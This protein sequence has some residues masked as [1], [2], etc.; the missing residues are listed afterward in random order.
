M[1]NIAHPQSSS[2][3]TRATAALIYTPPPSTA[4]HA[5]NASLFAPSSSSQAR[6]V[7]NTSTRNHTRTPGP[8]Y[9]ERY[10]QRYTLPSGIEEQP[11]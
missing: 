4:T 1:A 11:F 9:P 3:G 7:G 10:H 2:T 6:F 8:V 5:A